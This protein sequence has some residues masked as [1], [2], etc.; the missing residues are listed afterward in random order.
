MENARLKVQEKILAT[1]QSLALPNVEKVLALVDHIEKEELENQREKR[2]TPE[3]STCVL[4]FLVDCRLYLLSIKD[5]IE[6][7]REW[8]QQE[9]RLASLSCYAAMLPAIA[10]NTSVV[11]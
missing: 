11:L 10:Q 5:V 4:D 9:Q 6:R 3:E 1:I 2:R 7:L 8:A